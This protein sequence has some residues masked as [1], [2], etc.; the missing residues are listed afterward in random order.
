MDIIREIVRESWTALQRSRVRSVL[1]MLG[2]VWGIVAV[3]LLIAYG[4]GFRGVL[5][6]AFNAF[7]K[8]AVVAWPGQTSEQPGGQRAGKV[9]R[10]EQEDLELV[11]SNAT[12]VKHACLETVRTKPIVY[13]DRMVSTAIRGVCPEYGEI[14][15]E[16][17]ADGRWINGVDF[18]DRRRVAFIGQWVAD[19]LFAGRPAVGEE[20]QIGGVRFTII[21]VMAKKMQMSN[22]FT[23]DDRSIF[24]PYTSAG[25]LWNTRYANVMVFSPVAPQFEKKAEAQVLATVAERQRFSPTD[26]KAIQMFGR[27]EFRPIID[28]IT[29]GLQV[30]LMFIGG[31]TLGIG[32]VGVMNI[33]LVSVDERIREI[34]LRRALGARKFH[35]R[36]Q[37]LAEAM[38]MMMLGG[39]IGIAMA[40]LVA[41]IT[42]TLPM[43][44]PL[45][46]DT[47]GQGDIHL[48]IS[49]N[50]VL[51]S[52]LVLLIV[53]VIS[54]MVPAL[55]AAKLDPVEALRYE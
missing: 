23:S 33:M 46:E 10:F 34:G 9:V 21:G 44:G 5:V 27:E 16:V 19:K 26:K 37:F 55:R 47:T 40:Y 28:G 29:I 53:G 8:S 52:T 31:L 18:T 6:H 30:L 51:L 17:P 3:T 41:W 50:T 39:A 48:H 36:V 35:I 13:A 43:L 54:G 7:G 22:Y 32:G 14:R 49:M 38:L 25:D 2:I 1:T 42:P 11:R 4:A 15:N 24:I 20:V 12:L 45:F